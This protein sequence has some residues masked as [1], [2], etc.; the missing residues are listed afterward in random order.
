MTYSGEVL[1]AIMNDKRDFAIL[2]NQNW[3]RIPV[4]S[5]KKWLKNRWPPK[6]LAFYQTKVF[7]EEAYSIRYYSRVINIERVLRHQLFPNEPIGRKSQ[8]EYYQ[9][10]VNP[11]Q[12]LQKPIFS[13]RWR[14]I[15]FIP[16]TR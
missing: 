8:R 10:F 6:W 12:R 16:T 2:R 5:A 11:I 14:R 3:Y 7:G 15:I 13:R 9:L 4:F 1:V